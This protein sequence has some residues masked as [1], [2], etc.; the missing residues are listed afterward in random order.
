MN[1]TTLKPLTSE[2]KKKH[3]SAHISLFVW[4]ATS[5]LKRENGSK[6]EKKIK[7]KKCHWNLHINEKKYAFFLWLRRAKYVWMNEWMTAAKRMNSM[8]IAHIFYLFL[9]CT[10]NRHFFPID[11]LSF[12][13]NERTIHTHTHATSSDYTEFQQ[14]RALTFDFP[15]DFSLTVAPF[16]SLPPFKSICCESLT[17]FLLAL[18]SF[19]PIVHYYQCGT[20]VV[21]PFRENRGASHH[22]IWHGERSAFFITSRLCLFC[23]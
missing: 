6:W 19:P 18:F 20:Q 11:D 16:P 14:W 3:D 21:A 23:R 17:Y 22:E 15:A 12:V 8:C 4:R 7:R 2:R 5:T 1:W 10:P 9:F 13:L